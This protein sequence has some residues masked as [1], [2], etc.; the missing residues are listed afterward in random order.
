MSRGV[1]DLSPG[2]HSACSRAI[3]EG[4]YELRMVKAFGMNYEVVIFNEAN[5]IPVPC[6][7]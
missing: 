6:D 4:S 3:L 7:L 5:R 2:T 1:G